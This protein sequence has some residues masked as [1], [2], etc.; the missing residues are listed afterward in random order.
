[1]IEV[2]SRP[3]SIREAVSDS[4]AQS[5]ESGSETSDR[6]DAEEESEGEQGAAL[7]SRSDARSV[8]SFSSMMSSTSRDRERDKKDRK[9]L[10]DRLATVS[11]LSKFANARSPQREST[12]ETPTKVR[13]ALLRLFQIILM[14]NP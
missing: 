14:L 13:C 4:D 12:R 1:M 8:R 3:G 5:Q 9:S 10:S 2:P 7:D 6:S 11:G